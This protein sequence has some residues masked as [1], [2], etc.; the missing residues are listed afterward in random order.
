MDSHADHALRAAVKALA[1]VVA[2]AVNP[3]DA[4]AVDQLRLVISWLQFHDMRRRDEPRLAWATLRQRLAL[5]SQVRPVLDGA[6]SS[7]PAVQ[8]LAAALDRACSAARAVL[9]VPGE[10]GHDPAGAWAQAAEE[11]DALVCAAI[12]A[13]D[14][15]PEA[16]RLALARVVLDQAGDSLMLQRAWFAPLGFE[17]RPQAVPPLEALLSHTGPP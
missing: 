4:L 10:Q 6:A 17:A 3:D 12:E 13:L 8:G 14:T 9:E 5:A 11:L 7:G 16:A 15:G 2:P 1:E